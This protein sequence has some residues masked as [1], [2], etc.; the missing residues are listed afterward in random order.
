M[1][2]V[3][4]D[5]GKSGAVAHIHNGQL[6]GVQAFKGNIEECRKI[7]PSKHIIDPV[8]FIERVTSSPQ[9]GVASAFTFGKW[10]EAVE[11]TA[12]LT[13]HKVIMVR[14]QKW[15]NAIGVFSAGDKNVSYERAQKL[16]PNEY[17]MGMFN[18]ATADAVLIAY[19]GYRYII[20]QEE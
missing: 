2:I 5:P 20:Y 4:V 3:G 13:G 9:M 19:Y 14:P 12:I 18:Q 15:Q 7:A 16:F 6:V 17:K 10:A 1:Y 8:F 11:T